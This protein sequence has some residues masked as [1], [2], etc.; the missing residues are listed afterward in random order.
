MPDRF[1]L[2]AP[3]NVPQMKR[4]AGIHRAARQREEAEEAAGLQQFRRYCRRHTQRVLK[5]LRIGKTIG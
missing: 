2:A 5:I 3:R 4:P 1:L